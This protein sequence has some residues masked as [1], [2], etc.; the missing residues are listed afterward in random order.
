[1]HLF[2]AKGDYPESES[3]YIVALH[4]FAVFCRF[5]SAMRRNEQS[6]QTLRQSLNELWLLGWRKIWLL[7]KAH[8][9]TTSFRQLHL[10][11]K[12]WKIHPKIRLDPKIS[13]AFLIHPDSIW[14]LCATYPNLGMWRGPRFFS[15]AGPLE[16][17]ASWTLRE[18]A[19]F[20]PGG[21]PTV[22][23]T[24]EVSKRPED[25][26]LVAAAAKGDL[27]AVEAALPEAVVEA[28]VRLPGVGY[29]SWKRFKGFQCKVQ[30]CS[31]YSSN[32]SLNII[33]WYSA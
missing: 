9:S 2:E 7:Q 12:F 31:N 10:T 22:A 30:I 1:M 25:L 19:L 23:H 13:S 21:G 6:V 33:E 26:R 18:P 29:G 8:E 3:L 16:R 17:S 15:N 32:L 28:H 5:V 24:L 27:R 20:D 4:M 14:F 11:H